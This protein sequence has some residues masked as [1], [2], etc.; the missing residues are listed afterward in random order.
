M[1]SYDLEKE[2]LHKD[3]CGK[4]IIYNQQDGK[5]DVTVEQNSSNITEHLLKVTWQEL[6]DLKNQSVLEPGVFYR[7]TDYEFTST[8]PEVIN[9]GHRFDIIVLA[10]SENTLSEDA[11]AIQH[12]FTE[13]EKEIYSEEEQHYF[14]NSNLA[15]W[16][17]KYSLDGNSK[18]FAWA[19]FNLNP[20][21]KVWNGWEFRLYYRDPESD[22]EGF[23]GW[24]NSYSIIY[25]TTEVP[26]E[27]DGFYGYDSDQDKF[28][29]ESKYAYYSYKSYLVNCG[30]SWYYYDSQ[31]WSTQISSI[32]DLLQ[33]GDTISVFGGSDSYIVIE[34]VENIEYNGSI[35]PG[36]V[37][38]Y[39][40]I[41]YS[42]NG[43]YNTVS[44]RFN[45]TWS[46]NYKY[47]YASQSNDNV[48]IRSEEDLVIGQYYELYY[49]G[50]YSDDNYVHED[51]KPE[52]L[53][54]GFD[55][56]VQSY[57]N[58][59]IY[60]GVIYGMVD[61]YEND[62]EYDFKNALITGK[63]SV[64]DPDQFYYTFTNTAGSNPGYL[65]DNNYRMVLTPGT[66]SFLGPIPFKKYEITEEAKTFKIVTDDSEYESFDLY[67]AIS[68]E[69]ETDPKTNKTIYPVK[70]LYNYVKYRFYEE[71]KTDKKWYTTTP[72]P[73][74]SDFIYCEDLNTG[75]ATKYKFSSTT[76]TFTVGYTWGYYTSEG[77]SLDINYYNSDFDITE[78]EVRTTSG[79]S[80]FSGA[81]K[82]NGQD[83]G[84]KYYH[85]DTGKYYT[86]WFDKYLS[87]NKYSTYDY[88]TLTFST[89]ITIQETMYVYGPNHGSR[90]YIDDI[91]ISPDKNLGS[92]SK[93]YSVSKSSGLNLAL[94]DDV[95]LYDYVDSSTTILDCYFVTL[96][97]A[98]ISRYKYFLP[99]SILSNVRVSYSEVF[100]VAIQDCYCVKA[101]NGWGSGF[102]QDKDGNYLD[103]I[104]L[105]LKN[106]SF[107]ELWDA[108]DCTIEDCYS[109]TMNKTQ[110]SYIKNVYNSNIF[111]N[112]QTYVQNVGNSTIEHCESI[113]LLNFWGCKLF[114]C[115]G[116][117]FNHNTVSGFTDS[118]LY[119]IQHCDIN[120]NPEYSTSPGASVG[121]AKFYINGLKDVTWDLSEM[122]GSG[123][124]SYINKTYIT[125]VRSQ[126]DV[127]IT[128]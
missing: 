66:Y 120:N 5:F 2:F 121:L 112:H 19:P 110:G 3:N 106:V 41:S 16:K 62:C 126:N 88:T 36:Y 42:P 86:I 46:S 14:D 58:T 104:R 122:L 60:K 125:H 22:K 72:T 24:N 51:P 102:R 65:T 50:D 89:P 67:A 71:F 115:N 124:Y 98:N 34:P 123:K 116:Q 91:F 61:E 52:V 68:E 101:R 70:K 1:R 37:I 21:I 40:T 87:K 7:I 23:Y 74:S 29:S 47:Q 11:R 8:D 15:A 25:T 12:E 78:S 113:T 48:S 82:Y 92:K 76:N 39:S 97:N 79:L 105:F 54:I 96:K 119:N 107:S 32:S 117:G 103:N 108:D 26:N 81:S 109:I 100:N 77:H 18:R 59:T 85:F 128:V 127:T 53:F 73:T 31:G 83:V 27:K 90:I 57:S 80:N 84:L 95:T 111:N 55:N 45:Y 75:K 63:Y 69:S 118:I 35:Y 38:C 99:K 30:G 44:S 4:G 28:Y 6:V 43:N 49:N 10:L 9:A 33:S 64:F 114:N 17:L 93:L 56:Y 13:E 94:A 20:V